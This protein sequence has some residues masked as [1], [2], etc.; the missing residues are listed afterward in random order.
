MKD[1]KGLEGKTLAEQ[2]AYFEAQTKAAKTL[3]ELATLEKQAEVFEVTSTGAG[4]YARALV[5]HKAY[6]LFEAEKT[7]GTDI[8]QKDVAEK[9]GVGANTVS[10]AFNA[11]KGND[12]FLKDVADGKLTY[13]GRVR[14]TD[15]E[16]GKKQTR[17]PLER[18]ETH[19]DNLRNVYHKADSDTK[20]AIRTLARSKTPDLFV[21]QGGGAVEVE[22]VE[23]VEA[24]TK[25]PVI[26][27]A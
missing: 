7:A 27:S 23:G 2:V 19:L 4:I 18:A 26:A 9:L 15:K 8:K 25:P 11:I 17:T 22:A 21:I 3:A 24:G 12:D 20:E 16:N 10:M 1:K 14:R 5:F 6:T 13:D